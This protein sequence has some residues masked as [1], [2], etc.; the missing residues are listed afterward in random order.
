MALRAV[1]TRLASTTSAVNSA[2]PVLNA[3]PNKFFALKSKTL[4]G[5]D[6]DFAQL[7]G[8]VTLISTC[9]RVRSASPGCAALAAGADGGRP[10]VGARTVFSPR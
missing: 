8:K 5:K 10:A 6:F 3:D 9:G 1:A 2:V 4:D 7:K